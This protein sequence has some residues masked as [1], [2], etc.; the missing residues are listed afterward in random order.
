MILAQA[1]PPLGL[2]ALSGYII[3][4]V[5]ATF[6]AAL[7]AF[8]YSFSAARSRRSVRFFFALTLLASIV[9]GVFG[10]YLFSID[11]NPVPSNPTD[12]FWAVIMIATFALSAFAWWRASRFSTHVRAASR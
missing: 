4:G 8:G 1:L 5:P 11:R 12:R 3:V 10:I 2:M 6:A 7:L 9:N